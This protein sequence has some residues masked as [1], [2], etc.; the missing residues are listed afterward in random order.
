MRT[1]PLQND[2]AAPPQIGKAPLG[3]FMRSFQI[4]KVKQM[5][6]AL[7]IYNPHSHSRY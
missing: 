1:K 4:R 7:Q 6:R 2:R 5:S 3:L